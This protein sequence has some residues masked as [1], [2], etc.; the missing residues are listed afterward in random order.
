MVTAYPKLQW[1]ETSPHIIFPE[2]WN[3]FILGKFFIHSI[4]YSRSFSANRFR[5]H[6]P[7]SLHKS[8]FRHSL[9]VLLARSFRCRSHFT[10]SDIS[11][12][13][14]TVIIE[15]VSIISKPALDRFISRFHYRNIHSRNIRW[16]LHRFRRSSLLGG[17]RAK[18]RIRHR[19][20]WM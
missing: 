9:Q 5:D 4:R 2:V 17:S 1:A 10:A 6:I 7:K 19:Y 16:G 14:S 8:S 12:V 3:A 18:H 15:P 20:R 11:E 13:E